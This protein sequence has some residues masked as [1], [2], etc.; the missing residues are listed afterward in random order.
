MI[1]WFLFETRFGVLLLTLLEEKAGLA[2]VQAD[3]LGVQR[4][5]RPVAESGD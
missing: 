2:V 4:S 1:K 3:W 5:G